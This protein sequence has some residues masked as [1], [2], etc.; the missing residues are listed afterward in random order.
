M[1][2]LIIPVKVKLQEEGDSMNKLDIYV[3]VFKIVG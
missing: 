3:E 2:S 1:Y